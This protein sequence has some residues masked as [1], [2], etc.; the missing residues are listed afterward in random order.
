MR[1]TLRASLLVLLLQSLA[2][3]SLW[4]WFEQ[5]NHLFYLRGPW[6]WAIRRHLPELYKEFNGIDFGHAHLAETLLHSGDRCWDW[7]GIHRPGQTHTILYGCR[8]LDRLLIGAPARC[9]R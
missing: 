3:A 7:N 4:D 6:N 8:C 2:A 9:S 5:R 1:M